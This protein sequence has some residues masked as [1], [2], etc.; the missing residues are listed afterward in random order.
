MAGAAQGLAA[1]V[2]ALVVVEA[3]RRGVFLNAESSPQALLA[4][5]AGSPLSAVDGGLIVLTGTT[6]SL[7]GAWFAVRRTL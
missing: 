4:I 6:I 5:V 3:A 7:V 2:A 1:G